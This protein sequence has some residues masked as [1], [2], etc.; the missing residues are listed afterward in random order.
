LSR[1]RCGNN[2]P[3][4]L[5]SSGFTEQKLNYIHNNPVE[6]VIVDKAEEYLYRSARDYYYGKKTG[7]LDIEFL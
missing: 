3:K 5:Y 1:T 6:A 4:E 7:L 2:Q